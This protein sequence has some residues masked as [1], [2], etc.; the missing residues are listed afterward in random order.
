MWAT[1]ALTTALN[2]APAQ[3]GALD[4]KN[5]RVTYGVLG[6]E[7]KEA[8]EVLPGDIFNVA[9]DIEGLQVSDDGRVLYRMG[10]ELTKTGKKEPEF[11]Q[12]PRDLEAQNT[13]GGSRVPAFART[14]VGL[15]TP[16]GEYTLKVIITDRAK[17]MPQT[18]ELSRT[19]NVVPARL[20]LVQVSLFSYNDGNTSLPAPPLGVPGQAI[21]LHFAV[22]GFALDKDKMQPNVVTE[23]SVLDE[24]GKPV[25][26]KPFSGT[27]TEV[28]A[29]FKKI[30]PM[31]FPVQLNR[32]GKFKLQLKVTDKLANKTAE[33]SLD[34]TVVEQK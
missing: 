25:L 32:S 17:K 6:Q 15:D 3:A 31:D 22:V 1:L 10:M 9:F 27:T 33:Q 12:E 26:A 8:K 29:Q 34:L 18:K 4:L 21:L 2:L 30:L 20:G 16:P 23:V 19:F 13:L 28:G 11:K 5:V 7:R 14:T 24:S